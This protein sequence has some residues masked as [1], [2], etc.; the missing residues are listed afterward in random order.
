MHQSQKRFF[1]RERELILYRCF[2]GMSGDFFVFFKNHPQ[3]RPVS[4]AQDLIK[5]RFVGTFDE[6]PGPQQR[7]GIVKGFLLIDRLGFVAMTLKRNAWEK[8]Y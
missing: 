3:L 4:L 1:R 2:E 8:L 6:L 5:R 7:L